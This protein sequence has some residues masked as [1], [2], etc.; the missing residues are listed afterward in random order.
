MRSYLFRSAAAVLALLAAGCVNVDYVGQN[1]DPLPDEAPVAY[2]TARSEIPAGKYRIIGRAKI[3]TTRKHFDKYDIRE[4]LID[5]ARSRG[6]DAVALVSVK[7]IKIGVYEHE[8]SDDLDISLSTKHRGS[9]PAHE[10]FGEPAT[11]KGE[12]HGR[13]EVHLQALFLKD[14]E[15]LEAVLARRGRELDQL[16]KQPDP[17]VPGPAALVKPP[18]ADGDAAE[19][20]PAAGAQSK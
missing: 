18:E 11:L 15:A 13:R 1:F 19:T 16:V 14:R 4:F 6:A 7:K 20:V 9:L 12:A 8:A 5:E 2:F 17:A 3:K 10:T